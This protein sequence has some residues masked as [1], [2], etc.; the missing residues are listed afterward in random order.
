MRDVWAVPAQ[1]PAEGHMNKPKCIRTQG[2]E[3]MHLER[4]GRYGDDWSGIQTAGS[5][6]HHSL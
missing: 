3:M 4:K 6:V 2:Q 5:E 1:V